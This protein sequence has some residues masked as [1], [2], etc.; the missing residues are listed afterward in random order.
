MHFANFLFFFGQ[1][2][3]FLRR[4]VIIITPV[5]STKDSK[6]LR[7]NRYFLFNP[8][9]WHF[10]R[11]KIKNVIF[12]FVRFVLLAHTVSLRYIKNVTKSKLSLIETKTKKIKGKLITCISI[13]RNEC[14][15]KSKIYC[16]FLKFN[17]SWQTPETNIT[18][19]S[20]KIFRLFGFDNEPF[21]AFEVSNLATFIQS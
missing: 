17:W 7:R 12:G 8:P 20:C 5:N 10:K 11:T 15:Y 21:V 16:Q 4:L 19:N 9:G 14:F 13:K 3:G 18:S 2:F 1:N 6:E